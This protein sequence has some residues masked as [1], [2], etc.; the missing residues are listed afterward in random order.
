MVEL[1][2]ALFSK[3]LCPE[4]GAGLST[5]RVAIP[6][7]NVYA[8][9]ACGHCGRSFF[10][11]LPTGHFVNVPVSVGRADG[12]I[13]NCAP[14]HEWLSKVVSGSFPL[15]KNQV[16]IERV[17]YKTCR[18]A[19]LLNALDFLYGHSL[20]K[21]YNAQHHLDHDRDMGLIVIVP[22]ILAWMIPAGCAEAWIVDLTLRELQAGYESI[23]EFTSRQLERFDRVWISRAYSHPDFTSIDIERFTGIKP[24]DLHSFYDREPS[25]TFVLRED[26]WWFSNRT[27]YWLYRVARK[28]RWLKTAG[29]IL[30]RR[31]NRLVR[32]TIAIIRKQFPGAAFTIVGLGA[33]GSFNGFANDRRV[34]KADADSEREWCAIYSQ[35]QVVIGFHGSNMLLPTAF[36]AGCVEILPEDRYGNIVQDISVRYSDRRQLFFYRFASQYS[37]ARSVA[38]Q[39]ISIIRD[40]RQFYA[41][42]C[43]NVYG[44]E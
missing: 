18:D 5:G 6:G 7:M 9:C 34:L 28:L 16:A 13:Y 42:M 11:M 29:A 25:V 3:F 30:S 41:S 27:G 20:L 44:H 39:A 12:R 2:P 23:A 33:T 17:I 21:L 10:Q 14:G 38:N 26:R 19:I 40:Y 43:L 32:D 8:E 36:A 37:P 22:R 1:K 15:C 35:S 24:F 4:C 31:Q